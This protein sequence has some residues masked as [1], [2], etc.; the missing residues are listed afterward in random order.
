MTTTDTRI[1]ALTGDPEQQTVSLV[2][3]YRA[4]PADVWHAITTPERIARVLGA[5]RGPMPAAPGDEFHVEMGPDRVRRAQLI[6]CDAPRSLEYIWWSADDDPGTVR[7]RLT[8]VGD[9][10]E[11]SVTHD[12]LRPHWMTGYGAGW[13]VSLTALA[14]VLGEPAVPG[15]PPE[16][17]ELLRA[18]PLAIT[19]RLDA[20]IGRVWDAWT[21]EAGLASWW[22]SH[23][24]DVEVS[25]DPR[26]GGAYRFAAPE[27]GMA[28]SGE[29]LVVDPQRRLAFTW[30]WSDDDGASVDEAVDVTFA[31]DAGGTLLTIRHTGPWESD[32]PVE[33]YRQGWQF[34]VASLQSAI[35]RG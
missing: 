31:D 30:T 13:E 6:R 8:P 4:A 3:R 2:R 32:A 19:A 18:R 12:R 1:R 21:T 17:W 11:L 26:V 34:V 35:A 27:K 22:W 20:P 15:A 23:W 10:T 25:A 7:I 5:I 28:V 29:Y 14:E 24:S 9:E 16:H 33:S